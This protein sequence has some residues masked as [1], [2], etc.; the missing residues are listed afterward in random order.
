MESRPITIDPVPRPDR[1]LILAIETSSRQGSV[2]IADTHGILS[3]RPF[4]GQLRHSTEL[5]PTL[6][7]M[8]GQVSAH[9]RQIQEVYLAVGP[10]SFTGIRMGLTIAKT[11]HLALGCKIVGVDSL[12]VIA[13]NVPVEQI[14]DQVL[15]P[16]VD[17][18]KDRFYIAV[19]QKGSIATWADQPIP[20]LAK[21]VQD[22]IV[23]AEQ[24]LDLAAELQRPI[25]LLGDGLL[26]H[27]KRVK[28]PQIEVMDQQYWSPSALNVFRLARLRAAQGL[29]DDPI[30]LVPKYLM[31]PEVTSSG[32]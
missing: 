4:T 3:Y 15:I 10:G 12:D 29:Y 8:L 2:A 18:K 9:P 22:T 16:L 30:E 17:A 14:D 24:L 13:A 26:Y 23:T 7:A 19:Y 27:A 1:S 11:L 21:T 28:G 31:P 25:L 6:Q 20:G 5:F 32:Q